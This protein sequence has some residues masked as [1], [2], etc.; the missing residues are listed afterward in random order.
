MTTARGTV[1]GPLILFGLATF[2]LL[3]FQG[4]LSRGAF[5]VSIRTENTTVAGSGPQHCS[6]AAAL[7]EELAGIQR[8][9]QLFS[10]AAVCAGECR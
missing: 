10:E 9:L 4:L 7:V 8:H 1:Q 6:A 2:L 3:G 5:H